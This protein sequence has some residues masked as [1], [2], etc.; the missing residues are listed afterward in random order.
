MLLRQHYAQ[1]VTAADER[2]PA[3]VQS[4]RARNRSAIPPHVPRT[5]RHPVSDIWPI[6]W[7]DDDALYSTYG[8]GT[9]FVPKADRKLSCGFARV[10]GGP[11][12]FQGVN[13]R[14]PA[15]Q[16]G[17]GKSEPAKFAMSHPSLPC[18]VIAFASFTASLPAAAP[19]GPIPT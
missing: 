12:D 3:D 10:T 16:V 18:L 15:E 11:S 5:G 17:Q 9:R 7:A 6:T 1:R 13:I 14:S 19:T 8:D 2:H 4:A